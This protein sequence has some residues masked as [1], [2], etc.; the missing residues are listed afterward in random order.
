VRTPGLLSP[1]RRG[2]FR[3]LW[4][5][6]GAS[7][8]GDR[9]QELAQVWLVATLTG[10]SALAVG[11]VSILASLPQFLM[12]MGG[13]VADQVDRRRLLIVGQLAGAAV[14]GA[15][16]ALV[17]IGHVAP[18]HIYA[19][20]LVS[21]AIWT[22][23][24][25]AYKVVLTQAVPADEVRSAVALNSM[26]ETTAM[27]VVNAAGSVLLGLTG[28]PVAFLFNALSY[29]VAAGSLWC[30][31]GLGQR[32]ADGP[33]RLSVRR[34]FSGVRHG[35]VYLARQP[36]LLYPLL[37]TFVTVVV[38]TPAVGLLAAIVHRR[39]GSIVSLGFL[40]ASAS[41]GAFLGAV[42]AGSR[43]E[44]DVPMRRYALY[45]LAVT[46][47]LVLF[48][49]APVSVVTPLPLAAIGFT[50]FAEVVWNTSR[51]RL[52]AAPT[53]QARLQSITSMVFALGGAIGQL[54]GGIVLDRFG[55]A[56]LVGGAAVLGALS[57]GVLLR[58]H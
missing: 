14:A 5:G 17:L 21:G 37:F 26:T 18:G 22:L 13:A 10:S 3:L 7:Y 24:R 34:T 4:A 6:M 56:S 23:S 49:V 2:L 19:W 55:V 52:L 20:A 9:L 54:W 58:A 38:A 57:M 31:P 44:G 50:V 42:Y 15:V 16:G 11:W 47:A 46:V 51:V 29:S 28:L 40:M 12:P 39:G 45:G 48:A 27:M 32:T 36:S 35:V 1:L 33:Q 8:A 41:L 25:P 53:F 43:S 30:L